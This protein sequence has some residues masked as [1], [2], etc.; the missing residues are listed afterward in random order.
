MRIYLLLISAILTLESNGQTVKVLFDA[1]SAQMAGNADWVIDADTRNLKTGSGGGM[2]TGGNESNPQRIPTPAQSGITASTSGTYWAG[3]LSSWAVDLA[4]KGYTVET[5]PYN[6]LITYGVSTNTQ[7]LS[8][9]KVFI[10]DEPNIR[11]TSAEKI[12][13]LNFVAN[14]GGLFMIADHT[15][16]DRNNDGWDSPAIFNDFMTNNG[17]VSNPF[18][19]AFDL[20][21]FS[22]TSSNILNSATDPILHGVMGNVT[23]IQFNNGTSMTLNRTANMT[24]KGLVFKTG[25]S[26]TGTTLSLF[27]ASN[28]RSGKVCGLGDSSPPDDGSGD[29]NDALYSSYSSA[30]SGSHQKLLVNAVVWLATPGT[31]PRISAPSIAAASTL[32]MKLYPNPAGEQIH[33]SYVSDEKNASIVTVVDLTGHVVFSQILN[34]TGSAGELVLDLTSFAQGMYVVI[35]QNGKDAIT[36]RF[37]RQ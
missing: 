10:I 23:G 15:V 14:G 9:Y 36:Q 13:M 37:I 3:A 5:L 29:P 27:A 8:N 24:V 33:L 22:Q 16:S 17:S 12:A 2:V 4:K 21:N 35:L 1:S 25:A 18:G 26:T 7:D 28:Y 19:I 20:Q 31:A 30:V 6:G 32:G 34:Q 11:F